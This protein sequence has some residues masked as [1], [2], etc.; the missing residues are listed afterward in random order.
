MKKLLSTIISLTMI[1]SLCIFPS[2]SEGEQT[3]THGKYTYTI[4]DGEVTI[5]DFSTY[6]TAHTEIPAEIDGLPVTVIASD[7]F[8]LTRVTKITVPSSVKRIEN[9]AFRSAYAETIILENGIEYIGDKA[10]NSCLDITEI[11][12]PDSVTELG[13]G[14][15]YKCDKLKTVNLGKGITK[16][17]DSCFE[18]CS[19][20]ATVN[21]SS[22]ITEIG[23]SAFSHCK[24][25]TSFQLSEGIKEIPYSAFFGCSM[26]S[27]ITIPESVTAIGSSAFASCSSLKEIVLPNGL[28]TIGSNAFYGTGLKEIVVPQSV[29]SIGSEAFSSCISLEKA[30]F[31]CTLSGAL[32]VFTGCTSLK[33][34]AIPDGVEVLNACFL[35]CIELRTVYMPS[36]LEFV[37]YGTFSTCSKLTDIYYEGSEEEWNEKLLIDSFNPEFPDTVTIHFNASRDDALPQE[38]RLTLNDSEYMIK[39]GETIEIYAPLGIPYGLACFAF[40]RWSIEHGN[41]TLEDYESNS[42][43]LVMPD[44]DVKINTEYYLI[45]DIAVSEAINAMDILTLQSSVKN[46]SAYS[47]YSDVNMDG[48]VDAFDLIAL[49]SIIKGDY[50]Y[51]PYLAE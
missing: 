34:F 38:Y 16:I 26:L 2:S 13:T 15:F 14:V 3:Y 8:A 6:P 25:L 29:T 50:D 46:D 28:E 11:T 36:S 48:T 45:G 19:S 27:D 9:N 39:V 40:D 44:H 7:A 47:K 42:Q 51:A 37:S 24:M 5:V 20:L 12:I 1:C 41:V 32:E 49:M 18:E 31:N 43:Y 33:N 21:T 35:N 4:T 30:E 22:E 10:F 17:P 23:K